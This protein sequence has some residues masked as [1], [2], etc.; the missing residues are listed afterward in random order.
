MQQPL[1]LGNYK[2][3]T[4]LTI[5]DILNTDSFGGV[6]FFVKVDLLYP[7]SWPDSH[8]DLPLAPEKL[9]LKSEWLSDYATS[10]G[11]PTSGEAKLVETLFAKFFYACH[12]RN[13]KF[14]VEQGLTVTKLH[15]VL[16]FDQSCWLG[17]YISKST[18][19]RK[20]AQTDFDKNFFK[21]L[22]EACFSKT[23][24]TLRSRRQTNFSSTPMEAKV[25]TT[26][27]NFPK[28]RIIHDSV[29]SVNSTQS[30]T[31]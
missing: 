13:L 6:G 11:Y 1:P 30:S 16:Q 4:D 31:F 21:L 18:E 8:N 5:D 15:R 26:K 27:P 3:R 28:F 23:M 29:V 7:I 19:M 22:S 24:E 25:C 12:F 14:Y 9:N 17:T 20:N 10:L 2:W